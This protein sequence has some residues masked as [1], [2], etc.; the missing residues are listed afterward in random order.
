ML[1]RFFAPFEGELIGGATGSEV[2]LIAINEGRLLDFLTHSEFASKFSG[3]RSFV[4]KAL[5]GQSNQPGVLLVNLNLRSVA[6]GGRDSLVEKQ[7]T[8]MLSDTLWSPCNSCAR[9][10]RC[11]IKHNVDSLR[12]PASGLAVRERVRRLF[13]VQHLRRRAH[14]TMRDLRSSLSYMILRDHSCDDIG[15]L[16]DEGMPEDLAGL[17]YPNA[18]ADLDAEVGQ[19]LQSAFGRE[20]EE[21]GERAIDR[22]VRRLREVDIGL[23][24]APLLDRRLYHEPGT[25]VPWMTFEERS[26]TAWEVM[27][28]VTRNAPLPGDEDPIPN[29][30]Q[31][32]RQLIAVW[33]RWAFFE[34]R[35]DG[36][37]GMLP[38]RSTHLLERIIHPQ[39][40]ADLAEATQQLRDNVVDAVCLSEGVRSPTIR[41]RFLALKIT[42]IKEA[43]VRS[44]RLFPKEGFEVRV[45]RAAGL[46]DYLE[47]AP[48]SVELVESGT[49]VAKLR[50][51]LDLLEM[52]ELIRSGYRPTASELQGLFVNLLIFRNEL[53]TTTF[54]R[55][56]LTTDDQE[57]YEVAA[58]G[59]SEGIVLS[60]EKQKIPGVE[61]EEGVSP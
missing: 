9:R 17:Y 59:T 57:F 22:L 55:V 18:F 50:I 10:D 20:Q 49:G 11:P 28:E 54:N 14:V 6:A 26:R 27:L 7:L 61:Q 32:R 47:H 21:Q 40:E 30:L 29:L 58:E 52:L 23:V 1:A 43:S 35:D 34:R 19:P 25:A 4:L 48:D 56:L 8:A 24:N 42:R 53:L 41:G 12:D 44:Y 38:Y 31:K 5:H 13:E 3:L 37:R 46:T 15:R 45:T 16:L 36:W 39:D 33:R 2:R 60:L 51:S